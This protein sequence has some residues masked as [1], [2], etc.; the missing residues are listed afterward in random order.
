MGALT[1][2][3]S[4]LK[5]MAP[6]YNAVHGATASVGKTGVSDSSPIASDVRLFVL[7]ENPCGLFTKS[8]KFLLTCIT[9][10][11]F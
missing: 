9:L 7:F 11:C 6:L 4:L 8:S 5:K 2:N 1:K 10:I 3:V